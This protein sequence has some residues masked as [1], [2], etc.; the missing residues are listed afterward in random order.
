MAKGKMT[1]KKWEGSRADEKLD[2]KLG[3]KEGSAKDMAKDKKAV[4]RI[5]AG[6]MPA[7]KNGGK[8]KAMKKGG[9]C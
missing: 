6:M 7:M 8:V 3:L 9:K 1:M 4:N 5:N 2:K